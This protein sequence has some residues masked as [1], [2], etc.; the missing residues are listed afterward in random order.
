MS[1]PLVIYV[2]G[3]YSSTLKSDASC[4]QPDSFDIPSSLLKS[5]LLGNRGH[6][7]LTLPITWSPD[8]NGFFKQDQDDIYADG[9]LKTAQPKFF[10]RLELLAENDQID[11]HIVPWD[12]RRSFEE[13]EEVIS[14]QILS[15][16]KDDDRKAILITHSTGAMLTWPTINAHPELFTTWINAAGC[17]LLASNLFA[18]EYFEGWPV[19]GAEFI[20]ILGKKGMSLTC[21]FLQNIFYK[22]Y[23][24]LIRLTFVI[25]LA[26]FTFAGPYAYFPVKGEVWGGDGV[27][28]L[29]TTEGKIIG[30]FAGGN[31]DGVDLHDIETWKE[32]K[33]GIYGWKGEIGE[34][35]TPEE[36]L[37]LKH[38]LAVGKRFREKFLFRNGKEYT[39]SALDKPLSSYFH[40]KIICYG[41]DQFD[42]HSAYEIDMESKKIDVSE[43][44][45]KA[46]GDGTLYTKNW[47]NV[48]GGLNVEVI[49]SDPTS[50]HVALL[51]DDN[52][53][54]IMLDNFFPD[55]DVRKNEALKLLE[56]EE[57]EETE[58]QSE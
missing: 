1:K 21:C 57:P 14:T 9:P 2:P 49:L 50:G 56:L 44:K 18:K 51:D 11:L 45:V 17:L 41:N 20:N 40:L 5:V 3:L 19:P 8:E 42:T 7:N 32:Y 6:A 36:E 35:V 38:S 28:D 10:Q 16:C 26:F 12:W 46:K 23:L 29:I 22:K 55:D 24:F 34:E 4:F 53:H 39:P 30:N 52:L 15:I 47:Q 37:H 58:N 43:S 33:L 31:N 27:G 13:A 54:K 25:I 48:P